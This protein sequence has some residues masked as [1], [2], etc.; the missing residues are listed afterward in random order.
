MLHHTEKYDD[1]LRPIDFY[2]QF[3]EFL[4]FIGN[5]YCEEKILLLGESHYFPKNSTIHKNA[6]DWYNKSTKD[7][8]G[9][10]PYFINTRRVLNNLD[11]DK[12]AKKVIERKKWTKSRTIFRNIEQSLIDSKFTKTDNLLCHIAFMNTFLRPAENTGQSINVCQIDIEKSVLVINQVI[13]II[14]PKHICFVSSK[15]SKCIA[16][17]LT[18]RSDSVPHPASIWW[19]RKSKRGIG[20]ELFLNLL[21]SYQNCES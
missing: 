19:Y 1:S 8:S 18:M 15:A 7:L 11:W 20:K 13:E 3:P 6:V 5:N 4:P 12:K 16:K 2:K 17:D 21:K 9:D 10:E 14:R